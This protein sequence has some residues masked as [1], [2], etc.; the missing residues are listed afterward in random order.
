VSQGMAYKA[1]DNGFVSRADPARLQALCDEM[2]PV[3]ID[4]LL[5]R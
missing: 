5:R 2:R 4:G 3:H 1:L